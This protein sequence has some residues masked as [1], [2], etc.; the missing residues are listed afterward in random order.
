MVSIVHPITYIHV[1]CIM[2]KHVSI[3]SLFLVKHLLTKHTIS[4]CMSCLYHFVSLQLILWMKDSLSFSLPCTSCL[5]ICFALSSA[6]P[7]QLLSIL[8]L[9]SVENFYSSSRSLHT[10]FSLFTNKPLFFF[11]FLAQTV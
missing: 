3:L 11:F 4:I 1:L 6:G 9:I 8:S 10:C 5:I 7:S 2:Q